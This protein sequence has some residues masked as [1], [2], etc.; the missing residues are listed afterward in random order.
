MSGL[1]VVPLFLELVP[2]AF[3]VARILANTDADHFINIAIQVG[4]DLKYAKKCVEK[5]DEFLRPHQDLKIW[6][7]TTIWN[8][9]KALTEFVK[10]LPIVQEDKKK[11]SLSQKTDYLFN[12]DTVADLEKTL[13][14]SHSALLTGIGLVCQVPMHKSMAMADQATEPLR[15]SSMP[16]SVMARQQEM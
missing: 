11:A 8:T 7:N 2:T 14:Y 15:A 1:E 3:H 12:Q 13:K 6:L 10:H 9:D 5:M 16:P 4:N